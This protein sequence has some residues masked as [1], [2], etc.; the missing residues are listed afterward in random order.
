MQKTHFFYRKK[1]D[2]KKAY[3]ILHKRELG[4]YLELVY[5]VLLLRELTL[6]TAFL[7]YKKQRK[8][9]SNHRKLLMTYGY[10][11]NATGNMPVSVR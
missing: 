3:E 4:A 6:T 5:A 9:K 8:L 11:L 1:G 2:Q 7:S 10:W